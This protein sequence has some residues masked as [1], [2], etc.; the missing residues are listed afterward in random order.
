MRPAYLNEI[1]I[2]L[3]SSSDRNRHNVIWI[4]LI[5]TRSYEDGP[6]PLS[7]IVLRNVSE[8]RLPRRLKVKVSLLSLATGTISEDLV[9]IPWRNTYLASLRITSNDL[10][11]K[12]TSWLTPLTGW[13]KSI[14]TS[15]PVASM[16]EVEEGTLR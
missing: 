15:E 16:R 9:A 4:S 13:V 10:R 8:I 7:R 3:A 5:S 12:C 6:L 14:V 11:G 1:S 2:K